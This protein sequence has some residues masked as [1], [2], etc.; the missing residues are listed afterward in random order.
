MGLL[1]NLTARLG[2]EEEHWFSG[3][4]GSFKRSVKNSYT[5]NYQSYITN[6]RAGKMKYFLKYDVVPNPL[7]GS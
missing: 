5:R 1:H 4:V 3:Y 7:Q 2:G 6:V